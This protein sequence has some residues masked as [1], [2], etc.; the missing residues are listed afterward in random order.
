MFLFPQK[1]RVS[2]NGNNQINRSSCERR[3]EIS[4]FSSS[5]VTTNKRVANETKRQRERENF[6]VDRFGS[7]REETFLC[8]FFLFDKIFGNL[9]FINSIDI[10][11]KTTRAKPSKW[12]EKKPIRRHRLSKGFP[13]RRHSPMNSSSIRSIG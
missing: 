10:D 5:V 9:F 7:R 3:E 12:I 6:F 11:R 2:L 13:R 8:F 4:P 1:T